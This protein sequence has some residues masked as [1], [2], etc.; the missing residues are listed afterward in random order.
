M[1]V[2]EGVSRF[3]GES[4]AVLATGFDRP[5]KNIKTGP[6]VSLTILPTDQEPV[7]SNRDYTGGLVSKHTVCGDCPLAGHHRGC[8]VN[9]EQSITGIYRV[10]KGGRY[11]RLDLSKFASRAIRFGAWGEPSLI[12]LRLVRRITALARTW[13]G[14]THQWRH[15]WAQGYRSF[16][17]AS[18][19]TAE[20]KA[21]ANQAGWRT[22]RI[23]RSADQML[24]DEVLCPATTPRAKPVQCITCGLCRGAS[25]K[26]KNVAVVA[27]GGYTRLNAITKYLKGV[28]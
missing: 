10:F 12:P 2:H 15:R 21:Q 9:V 11:P 22:F 20:G 8:Y 17:M 5:S 27:H 18:V 14:Y 6:M 25:L 24:P 1:I 16:L 13:T 7:E 28:S 3:S 26:A 23:I 19:E 4:F